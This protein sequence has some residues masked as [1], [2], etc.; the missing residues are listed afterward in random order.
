MPMATNEEQREYQRK[1]MAKRRADWLR[2]KC[3]VKCCSTENLQV[4]HVDPST[5]IDHK[6]WSWSKERRDAE[7]SKCQVLCR[8]CHQEKTTKESYRPDRHGLGGYH[9]RRCRCDICKAAHTIAARIYK[10]KRNAASD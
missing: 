5:K 1:W 3:C 7:L 8:A 9:N 4:D 6:V 10:E 2:G